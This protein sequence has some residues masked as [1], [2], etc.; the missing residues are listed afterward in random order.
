[1]LLRSGAFVVGLAARAGDAQDLGRTA[2]H[3][4]RGAE[5]FRGAARRHIR[6]ETAGRKE[7]GVQRGG[8][9]GKWR[10]PWRFPRR[11]RRKGSFKY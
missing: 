5:G 4:T 7:A 6:Q 3:L 9:F 1:M 10:R 8:S 2:D 11:R